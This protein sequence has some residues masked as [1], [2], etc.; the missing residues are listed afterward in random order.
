MAKDGLHIVC[1]H[2]DSVNRLPRDRP[3]LEGKCGRC[4]RAL[5]DGRA[6]AIK[7]ASFDRHIESSGIPVLVDFW[8]DWCGPCKAMAP[9]LESLAGRL[10]PRLRV[11][12][13]DTDDEPNL[14]ARFGIRS[15]PTLILFQG[16]KILAQR[17]G[18]VPEA[19]LNGWLGQYLPALARS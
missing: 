12:K 10:Q 1:A 15:I 5:F 8:A 14:A 13:V 6:Y 3:P 4:H 18:A 7:G 16:G 2:C 11:L 17:S 19:A 9:K